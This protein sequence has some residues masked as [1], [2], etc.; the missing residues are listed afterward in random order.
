MDK[1]R[2]DEIL[3]KVARDHHITPEQ[4]RADMEEALEAGQADTDPVV[5]ARWKQIPHKGDKV[6]LEEFMDYAAGVLNHRS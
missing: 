6:T 5:R 4:A 1:K 3:E 2:L